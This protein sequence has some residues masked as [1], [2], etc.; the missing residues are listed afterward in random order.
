MNRKGATLICLLTVFAAILGADDRSIPA[1]D[2]RLVRI[3]DCQITLIDHVTLASDR[4]GILK[5]VEFKEG[6]TVP[7]GSQVAVIA[8][9]VA[10]ANLAVAEK[11][12]DQ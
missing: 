5:H 11:K 3:L 2:T 12:S 1:G 10:K 7:A 9:D 4:S 6:Q 8:D